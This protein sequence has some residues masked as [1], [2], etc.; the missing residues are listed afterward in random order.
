MRPVKVSFTESGG[1]VPIWRGC[2]VDTDS[3]SAG[4]AV[5]LRELVASSGIAGL[6]DLRLKGGADYHT[7]SIDIKG[8]GLDHRVVI[9]LPLAPP[10]AQPLIR[11][12]RARSRNLLAES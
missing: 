9:D 4:D 5:Q 8:E 2:A 3:L 12:L 6:R 7:I 11:F 10:A 1:L